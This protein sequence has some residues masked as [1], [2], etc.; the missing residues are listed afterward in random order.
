MVDVAFDW[1]TLAAAVVVAGVALEFACGAAVAA[2]A[3]ETGDAAIVA[4]EGGAGL[5]GGAL[6]LEVVVF[7][8]EADPVVVADVFEAGA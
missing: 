4:A 3:V 7:A 6:G 2:G 5:A 1:A 8:V